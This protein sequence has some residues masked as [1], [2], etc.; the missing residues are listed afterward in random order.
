MTLSQPKSFTF[1]I[2]SFISLGWGRGTKGHSQWTSVW[3]WAAW[4]SHIY[5]K[6]NKKSLLCFLAL[7]SC[8]M[9]LQ[10]PQA[11]LTEIT[12]WNDVLCQGCLYL[13][14]A[15][16]L[17]ILS[18]DWS[19]HKVTMLHLMCWRAMWCLQRNLPLIFLLF[20]LSD[21]TGKTGKSE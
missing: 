9:A 6:N 12:S 16:A 19:D 11:A 20:L 21:F 17:W 8:C 18:Q 3:C 1:P 2:L 10:W 5:F 4:S 13:D 14:K 7:C 15:S